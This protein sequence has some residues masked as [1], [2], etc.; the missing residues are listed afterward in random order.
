MSITNNNSGKTKLDKYIAKHL[1]AVHWRTIEERDN[2]Y[3]VCIGFTEAHKGDCQYWFDVEKDKP[4]EMS[5]LKD[6]FKEIEKR[7]AQ[8]GI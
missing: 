8:R 3:L 1:K 4:G 5:R 7:A 6:L 2:H